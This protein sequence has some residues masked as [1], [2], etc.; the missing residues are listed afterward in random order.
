[1]GGRCCEQRYLNYHSPEYG[2]SSVMSMQ[3]SMSTTYHGLKSSPQ[4]YAFT[5]PRWDVLSAHA[6]KSLYE[7]R[8]DVHLLQHK[9]CSGP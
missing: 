9:C 8:Y 1:M 5:A 6:G 2:I 3:I 4:R 7:P